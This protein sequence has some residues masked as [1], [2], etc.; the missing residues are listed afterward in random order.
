MF[1]KERFFGNCRGQSLGSFHTFLEER[2]EHVCVRLNQ[3]VLNEKWSLQE[4]SA[5]KP[6]SFRYT[7]KKFPSNLLNNRWEKAINILHSRL[8]QTRSKITKYWIRW[9]IYPIDLKCLRYLGNQLTFKIL[10]RHYAQRKAVE[11]WKIEIE[12]E[13]RQYK[14]D[15]MESI[16]NMYVCF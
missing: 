16:L 5:A 3:S 15:S 2:K 6:G 12:L 14:N 13:L 9:Y 4:M 8:L 11:S 7:M 1:E 10:D